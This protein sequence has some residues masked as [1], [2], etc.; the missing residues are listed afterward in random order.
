MSAERYD[1]V[2]FNA[3]GNSFMY[4]RKRSGPK[5]DPCGTPQFISPTSEKTF[6]SVTKNFLFQRHNSVTGKFFS[7]GS[8]TDRG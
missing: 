4:I 3:C 8:F 1:P 7:P 5:I 2:S 6:S